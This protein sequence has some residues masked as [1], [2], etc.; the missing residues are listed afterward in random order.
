[1]MPLPWAI[2][3]FFA[4]VG[5]SQDGPK[6]GAVASES[7]VCSRIGTRLL[8]SGGSAADA[9]VGTILCVGT[10]A[11]YHSGIGGG[12]FMTIRAAGG[13][14]YETVDFREVAPAAAFEDMF[15][16]NS[17][18]SN[19]GGL[20]S[21]VPGELRGLQYLHT[22]YG[23][24]DWSQLVMPSVHLARYGFVVTDDLASRMSSEANSFLTGDPAWAMDFAP[25]GRRLQKGQVMT[26]K[27]YADTLERIAVDG[28]DA[29]Y[30]GAIAQATIAALQARNGTMTMA[31]LA[32]YAVVHRKPVHIDYRGVRL[33]SCNAPSGG[34]VA[35]SALNIL[36]G[37][38]RFGD[39]FHLDTHRLDE[40]IKLA[41]GQ[42]TKL[43]DPSFT[44]VANLTAAMVSPQHGH[45]LR[46]QI[47]DLTTR[48]VSWYDPDRF[49]SHDS[50]G[51][52][53]MV[54]ADAT[55]LAVSLTT[56]VNAL[57]GSRLMVPETGI[58]MN[59]QMNDFSIPGVSNGY[60]YVPSPSNFIRPGKR[61]LSSIS[62]V[63]AETSQGRLLFSIGAA[64]GSRI[65]TATIQ[66]IIHL[67][68]RRMNMADALG[69]PRLH[70]QL[71]PP[72]VSFEYPF[73][74]GTVAFMKS[75]H[76]NVTWVAPGQSTAQGLRLLP[77]GTFEAAGE[78][79]QLNSGGFAV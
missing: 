39:S 40:A 25:R 78:P 74:N 49:E 34:I 67:L 63:I 37:Y 3:L 76:H 46:S 44:D 17:D 61:P 45:R 72:H 51:T 73:D 23:K 4:A 7:A 62:P 29:F 66:N 20:A 28:V 64:G 11:M 21:G 9:I 24:L 43:G 50:R 70:D 12:G 56:T 32:N 31:D 35:L 68:D 6:L 48:D 77:N 18:A 8:Q 19:F 55:G 30:S 60:G 54:A 10:V 69:Q 15:K 42:R 57:F 79:R 2:S 58:V 38:D 1:M 13:E 27:R 71:L 53:H 41:Y 47:S 36:G 5:A 26:R 75:L 59:N 14:R 22:K 16:N 65:T 33:T 52:S